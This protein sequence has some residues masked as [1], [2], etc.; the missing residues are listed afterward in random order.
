[1]EN[2]RENPKEYIQFSSDEDAR[3][4]G[5]RA[6]GVPKIL[7]GITDISS[8]VINRAMGVPKSAEAF[9]VGRSYPNKNHEIIEYPVMFYRKSEGGFWRKIWDSVNGK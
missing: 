3:E 5:Y 6:I 2:E 7:M 1:M 4:K 9:V 8:E